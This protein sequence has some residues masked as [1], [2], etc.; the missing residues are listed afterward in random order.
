MLEYLCYMNNRTSDNSIVVMAKHWQTGP[1]K[2]RLAESI[3][4]TK[5]RQIYR[6]MASNF[7]G[8]LQSD[9]W[10]RHLW[11]ATSDSTTELGEWLSDYDSL[12]TQ[13]GSDLG[14]RMLHALQAT[15]YNNWIAVSGTDAPDLDPDYINELCSH[16]NEND[17]AIAP[18]FDG[19]YAFMAMHKVC[20]QLFDGI[21]WST[22]HVLQQTVAAA[23]SC[24]L[25]VH[26]GPLLH[27]LDTID[28]LKRFDQRGLDWARLSS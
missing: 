10:Q 5:A 7:W 2:T 23:Y 18:T 19:G 17:V 11:S 28:D 4:D 22:E 15:T 25:K 13:Q 24:N 8:R 14:K 6:E 21:D 16:L 9:N 26:F 27:D 12:C 20:P 3:G 1:V